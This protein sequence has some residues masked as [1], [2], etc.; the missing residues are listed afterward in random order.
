[1]EEG[2]CRLFNRIRQEFLSWSKE[3]EKNFQSGKYLVQSGLPSLT[4]LY[5]TVIDNRKPSLTVL[6]ARK[7]K[8][9]VPEDEGTGERSI[10]APKVV[11]SSLVLMCGR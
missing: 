11:P 7:S 3:I 8:V 6:G 5:S 9:K 10:S 4:I 1:M 2:E